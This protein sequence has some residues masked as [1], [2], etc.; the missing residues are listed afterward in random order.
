[1]TENWRLAEVTEAAE[2]MEIIP[3][4]SRESTIFN[5]RGRRLSQRK[6]AG[7]YFLCGSSLCASFSCGKDFGLILA[8]QSSFFATS[9][10]T[11]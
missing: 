2:R 6:S 8:T 7:Q 1:V 4:L 9:S 10:F 11:S 3:P 5:H